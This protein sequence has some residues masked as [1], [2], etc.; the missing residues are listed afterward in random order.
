MT[1]LLKLQAALAEKGL[2]SYMSSPTVLIVSGSEPAMPTGNCFW[3]RRKNR[4]WY[5]GT[6]LPCGYELSKGMDIVEV[7]AK[8]FSSCETAIYSI[9]PDLAQ[10]LG[11][12]R[13]T[14][15]ELDLF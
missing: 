10:E 13:L 5:L 8:V 9:A 12:R 1:A 2:G 15:E 11:L 7:C 6:W 3:V 4:T 14:D